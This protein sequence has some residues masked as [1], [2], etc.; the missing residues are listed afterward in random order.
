MAATP[1]RVPPFPKA[2]GVG[3]A[4][5]GTSSK[6]A[7]RSYEPAEVATPPGDSHAPARGTRISVARGGGGGAMRGRVHVP[8]VFVPAERG[9]WAWRR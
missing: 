2:V 8:A 9:P 4:E 7:T 3:D 1:P 5:G 6:V